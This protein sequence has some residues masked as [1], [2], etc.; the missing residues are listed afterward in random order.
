MIPFFSKWLSLK[1][2]LREEIHA[3][4][5]RDE[6]ASMTDKVCAHI[7]LQKASVHFS[8]GII[9]GFNHERAEMYN[10]MKIH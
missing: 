6:I 8:L 5:D 3:K 9:I 7:I 4:I 2:K 1:D 10:S